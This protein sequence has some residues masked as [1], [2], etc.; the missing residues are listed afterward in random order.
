MLSITTGV[1]GMHRNLCLHEDV[2]HDHN[3]VHRQLPCVVMLIRAAGLAAASRDGG[4]GDDQHKRCGSNDNSPTLRAVSGACRAVSADTM[5]ERSGCRVL[6]LSWHTQELTR[7]NLLMRRGHRRR[8]AG[9]SMLCT[10]NGWDA[11]G[12]AVAWPRCI[13]LR[14][15]R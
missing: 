1:K 7:F 2:R 4:V 12:G 14:I 15:H 8:D 11:C 3:W 10:W 13:L 6:A 9:A 5:A